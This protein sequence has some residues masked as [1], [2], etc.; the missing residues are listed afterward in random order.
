MC[1]FVFVFYTSFMCVFSMCFIH[2]ICNIKW[3]KHIEK[4]QESRKKTH[5]HKNIKK[6]YH[7][8][9]AFVSFMSEFFMGVF[10]CVP[11]ASEWVFMCFMNV[12]CVLR[13]YRCVVLCALRFIWVF[14]DVL[15]FMRV[16]RFMLLSVCFMGVLSCFI[17]AC[18]VL[19]RVLCMFYKCFM[20]VW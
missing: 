6:R 4:T 20:N 12:L 19:Y 9:N 14:Y 3:I 1:S 17:R 13:F 2:F 15:C 11:Y 8:K 5:T 16:L 18:M 10:L 7:A